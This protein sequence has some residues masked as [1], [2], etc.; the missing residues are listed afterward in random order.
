MAEIKIK[1]Q[2]VFVD[3]EDVEFLNKFHWRLT[4]SGYAYATVYMHRLVMST[5]IGRETHHK[6][7]NRLNNRK[8]NLENMSRDDHRKECNHGGGWRGKKKSS[9]LKGVSKRGNHRWRAVLYIGKKHHHLGYFP[10]EKEARSAYLN[11]RRKLG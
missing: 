1:N 7:R 11:A 3:D 9:P 6:D 2:V 10:T 5:P 8:I 4:P